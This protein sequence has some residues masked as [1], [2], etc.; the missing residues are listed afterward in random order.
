[1]QD[2]LK[3]LDNL[4]QLY[5]AITSE[6]FE[7]SILSIIREELEKLRPAYECESLREMAT[8]KGKARAYK[9]V[10]N[11]L[12]KETLAQRIVYLKK[13]IEKLDKGA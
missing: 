11:L 9:K 4:T 5:S 13:E 8:L 7:A 12:D 3:E 1:M 6:V 10:L 2:K